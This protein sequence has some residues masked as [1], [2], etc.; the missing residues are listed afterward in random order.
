MLDFEPTPEDKAARNYLIG[1]A[2]V[3]LAVLIAISITIAK[4]FF[5]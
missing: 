4:L 2:A 5:I 1:C 3:V